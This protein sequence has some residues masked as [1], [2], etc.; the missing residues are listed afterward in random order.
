MKKCLPSS[1]DG[2][3]GWVARV[4]K[5]NKIGLEGNRGLDICSLLSPTVQDSI[6]DSVSA[7]TA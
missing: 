6:N 1:V 7:A 5:F 4:D 2:W 3:W